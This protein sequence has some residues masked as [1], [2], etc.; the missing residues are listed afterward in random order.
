M[1]ADAAEGKNPLATKRARKAAEIEAANNIFEHL[2]R[3]WYAT[4]CKTW[5][6]GTALRTIGALELHMFPVFGKRP[7]IS[8]LPM[9]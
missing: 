6:E 5:T 9:E 2:A 4:K 3:K 7:Y 1:Q 8:I